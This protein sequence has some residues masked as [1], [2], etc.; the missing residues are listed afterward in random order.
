MK[1]ILRFL[2][3]GLLFFGAGRFCHRQ[4]RG[5]T[6][7]KISSDS[8]VASHEEIDTE[9]ETV[10]NQ[11]FSFLSSGGQCYAFLSEDKTTVIKFFKHHHIRMWNWLNRIPLPFVRKIL[12]Q[13]KHQSPQ[14]FESCRIAY[15]D[16][17]ERSGLIYLH[18]NKTRC[19][20]RPLKIIDNLGIAH[21]IDL[22]STDFALQRYAELSHR[23]F[24]ALIRNR[25]FDSAKQCIDSLIGLIIE[26]SQKG[27]ADR[28]FNTRTNIGFLGTQAVEI[29]LGSFTKEQQS[30]DLAKQTQ[31]FHAWLS[32]QDPVLAD[33]LAEKIAQNSFAK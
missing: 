16:F 23:K 17:K 22:N 26:R 14:F 11:P 9:L 19:F 29:D 12:E 25:D 15:E 4:T 31:K 28:D 13:K 27:I 6:L 32:K 18:L 1:W 21:L 33:Y 8:P 20:H 3:A 7:L 30:L 10:L 2:L 24:R 5:F